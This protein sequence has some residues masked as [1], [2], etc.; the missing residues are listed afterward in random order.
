MGRG[1]GFYFVVPEW[2]DFYEE[3]DQ[4]RDI[5]ICTYRYIW[6]A[7][8]KEHTQQT[9]PNT[10]WYLGK[11]RR[12]WM[13]AGQANKNMNYGDVN[14]CPLRYSDVVLMAAEAY[15]ELGETANAWDLINSVRSR[16]GATS[17]S[18]SNYQ[19]FIGRNLAKMPVNEFID[20][21]SEQGKIRVVLYFERGLE[22]AFEG[23]RK[24]D[25][26]RWGVLD[27]ALKMFGERSTV[28]SGTNKPYEAYNNFI[29][30]QHELFP[31]PLKEMQS[32][33]AL[34]GMNNNGF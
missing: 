23:Q 13:P 22:L 19:R 3:V 5:A 12:E 32:N 26:I 11:W 16:A 33:H 14:F 7:D 29:H 25:L 8:T 31:I 27:K 15:N 9:R 4:R 20:D 6:N 34:K 21:S 10:S 28:N 30:G 2:Y 18:L 17:L 1:Q 24:Y